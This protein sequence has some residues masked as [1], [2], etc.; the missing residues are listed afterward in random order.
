MASAFVLVAIMLR[1]L[2][3]GYGPVEVCEGTVTFLPRE[4]EALGR[5][6][7]AKEPSIFY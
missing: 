5:E 6:V 4:F 7:A 2:S 1:G 3:T